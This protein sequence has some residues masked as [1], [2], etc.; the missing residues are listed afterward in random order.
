MRTIQIQLAALS[1]LML[2]VFITGCSIQKRT[3]RPGFHIER[4]GALNKK[5]SHQVQA[6]E[7]ANLP[8][9]PNE[10]VGLSY[11]PLAAEAFAEDTD[12]L[13]RHKL[14]SL[15]TVPHPQSIESQ[16]LQRE[17][18]P[19][20]SDSTSTSVI[21]D[22]EAR[23]N[24]ELLL[25]KIAKAEK[26]LRIFNFLMIVPGILLYGFP[27]FLFR[28]RKKSQ[29]SALRKEA[30]MHYELA[31]YNTER[32]FIALPLIPIFFCALMCRRI[33]KKRIRNGAEPL[34]WKSKTIFFTILSFFVSLMLNT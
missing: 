2:V 30:N 29:I 13:N 15:T 4:I 16:S 23:W 22:L 3:L 6:Q 17:L 10:S 34:S 7:T 1:G 26:A 20:H 19:A 14:E 28:S 31:W 33:D 21:D 32:I 9:L 8:V 27:F 25:N 24:R 18:S 11:T 12:P 5:P